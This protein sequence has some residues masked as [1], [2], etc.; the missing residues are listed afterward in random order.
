MIQPTDLSDAALRER[1]EAVC[2]EFTPIYTHW[3]DL[4]QILLREF[5]ALRDAARAEQREAEAKEHEQWK[6]RYDNLSHW[7]PQT[8]AGKLEDFCDGADAMYVECRSDDERLGYTTGRAALIGQ[9]RRLATTI[10]SGR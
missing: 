9:I 6:F 7:L 4:P 8:I 10:R 1:A 5:L 3:G 2:N